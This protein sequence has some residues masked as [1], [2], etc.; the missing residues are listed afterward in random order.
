MLWCYLRSCDG[1]ASCIQ[2]TSGRKG[3]SSTPSYFLS[4]R[5]IIIIGSFGQSTKLT[6]NRHKLENITLQHF[7]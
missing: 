1:I 4:F 6:I 5:G 7:L 3:G 2:F